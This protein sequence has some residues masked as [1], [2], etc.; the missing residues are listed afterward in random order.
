MRALIR[1]LRLIRTS[2]PLL[3]IVHIATGMPCLVDSPC[4]RQ[5]PFQ[6]AP[7]VIASGKAAAVALCSVSPT[8][9]QL[10]WRVSVR[11]QSPV[12]ICS[13]VLHTGGYS[14]SEITL[15]SS[16]IPQPHQCIRKY[17]L[18]RFFFFFCKKGESHNEDH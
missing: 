4:T 18:P 5:A 15:S 13:F 17:L 16:F 6:D 9:P 8:V 11:A 10:I 7:A 12:F 14:N 3:P 1:H 2:F